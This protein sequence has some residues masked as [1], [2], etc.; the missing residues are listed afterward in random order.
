MEELH[1]P[2]V[3]LTLWVDARMAELIVILLRAFSRKTVSCHKDAILGMTIRISDATAIQFQWAMPF[4]TLQ[5]EHIFL[6]Q[7]RDHDLHD[8]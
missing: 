6:K 4:L 8:F 2:V 5:M 7:V 1:N 3:I